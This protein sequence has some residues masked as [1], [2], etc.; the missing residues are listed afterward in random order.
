MIAGDQLQIRL[1]EKVQASGTQRVIYESVVAGVQS[2]PTWV[3]PSLILINGW[4][5]TLKTLA[6]T[7]ITVEWSIRKLG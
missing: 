5:M 7:S 2:P 4:D 6:G 3:S 1:Y